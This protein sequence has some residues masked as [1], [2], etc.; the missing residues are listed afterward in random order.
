MDI[1]QFAK[2]HLHSTQLEKNKFI[3]CKWK[4]KDLG[5]FYQ[6]VISD[7]SKNIWKK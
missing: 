4:V 1:K 3:H 5:E 2:Q 7:R 6:L